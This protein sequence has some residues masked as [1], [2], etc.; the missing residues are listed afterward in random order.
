MPSPMRSPKDRWSRA[1]CSNSQTARMFL[2]T[3]L[4]AGAPFSSRAEEFAVFVLLSCRSNFFVSSPFQAKLWVLGVSLHLDVQK[5]TRSV[6]CKYRIHR[7]ESPSF[8]AAHGLRNLRLQG[9]GSMEVQLVRVQ[10]VVPGQM[11][12]RPR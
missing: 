8:P 2:T 6:S 7:L 3:M 4:D 12:G 9:E 1:C 10:V 11:N 5:C